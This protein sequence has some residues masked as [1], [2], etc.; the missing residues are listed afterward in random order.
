MKVIATIFKII[1]VFLWVTILYYFSLPILELVC[2]S[3]M[4]NYTQFTL[5][6]FCWLI[7]CGVTSGVIMAQMFKEN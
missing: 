2:A 5:W 4:L 6:W 7:I 3:K 1:G